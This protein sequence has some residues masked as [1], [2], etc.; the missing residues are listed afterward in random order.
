M[1]AVT[2]LWSMAVA[3]SALI[4]MDHATIWIHDRKARASLALAVAAVALVG[5]AVSEL[6]MMSSRWPAEWAHWVRWTHAPKLAVFRI[7][8]PAL[9]VEAA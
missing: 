3:G 1:N 2:L 8:L 7:Q 6:G 4:A 9:N 5:I